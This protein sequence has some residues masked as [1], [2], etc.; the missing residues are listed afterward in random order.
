MLPLGGVEL[1]KTCLTHPPRRLDNGFLVQPVDWRDGFIDDPASG[2]RWAQNHSAAYGGRESPYWRQ[3]YEMELIR[4]GDLRWPMMRVDIHVKTIPRR[5]L[6]GMD[7][8]LYRSFDHGIRHPSCC[9]WFGVARNGDMY[10]YRQYYR[11]DADVPTLCKEIRDRTEPNERVVSTVA[12]PSIWRRQPEGLTVLAQA[13]ANANLPLVRADNSASGY[14]ELTARLMSSIARVAVSKRNPDMVRD[15][16]GAQDLEPGT[17]ERIAESP[18]IWFHPD[19][20]VGAMSLYHECANLR[21]REMKGDASHR[22]APIKTEDIDDEGPDVVRYAIMTPGV[23]WTRNRPEPE[24]DLYAPDDL[25]ARAMQSH[26]E[27]ASRRGVM[28]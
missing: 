8:T 13:F 27:H 4:G 14:D 2:E 12:D 18:A 24:R 22:A 26:D 1:P 19:V 3:N 16:L 20:A 15:A 10:F 21:Y 17:I 9:A 28:P 5:E 25:L 23:V 11:V 6:L 7:W